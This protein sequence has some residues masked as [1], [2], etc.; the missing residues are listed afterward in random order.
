[1]GEQNKSK[2]KFQQLQL[3]KPA[4]APDSGTVVRLRVPAPASCVPANS[5]ISSSR[6]EPRSKWSPSLQTKGVNSNTSDPSELT[7]RD[8]Q[9]EIDGLPASCSRHTRSEQQQVPPRLQTKGSK[10]CR[11]FTSRQ[12]NIFLKRN[13]LFRIK[14][15]QLNCERTFERQ[16]LLSCV[17]HKKGFSLLFQKSC[18]HSTKQR[19]HFFFHLKHRHWHHNSRYTTLSCHFSKMHKY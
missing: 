7:H 13:N 19:G 15:K 14:Q 17:S 8:S 11:Q 18:V 3:F 12:K 2:L 16:L 9:N 10:V 1:M 5:T 6:W 4:K